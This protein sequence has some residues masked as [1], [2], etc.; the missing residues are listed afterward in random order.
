MSVPVLSVDVERALTLSREPAPPSPASPPSPPRLVHEAVTGRL[1]AA[2]FTV[3]RELGYGFAD[4]V[5]LRALQL[6]LAFRGVDVQGSV[7]M[8]VFYKGR[9]VGTYSADL[10]VEGKVVAAVRSGAEVSDTD[11]AQLLNWMR[12]SSADVGMLLHF[13]PRPEF[14]RFLGRPLVESLRASRDAAPGCSGH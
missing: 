1:L 10:L 9:K 14:R 2:F 11:R 7:P 13:G 5:Y 8:G 12:C 4:A 3:H 6:E